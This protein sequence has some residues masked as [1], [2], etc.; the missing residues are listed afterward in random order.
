[1]SFLP[2]SGNS[3]QNVAAFVVGNVLRIISYWLP[4]LPVSGTLAIIVI[5]HV[6]NRI[7]YGTR[8][9]N[10]ALAQVHRDLEENAQ[11]CGTKNVTIM[12]RIIVPLIKPSLLY[13]ALWTAMLSF[14]EVTM[15]LFLSGPR[16]QVL[17]VSI[18]LLWEEGDLVIAAAGA[19]AIV[20]IAGAL[21]FLILR[22]TGASGIGHIGGLA[23]VPPAGIK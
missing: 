7:P 10:A 13:L 18:W 3:T 17:S 12:W 6:I 9:N 5:A 21:V 20:T 14:Q 16:N 15:A 4:W 1:M 2:G 11:V 22:L 8:V 19:V 23:R